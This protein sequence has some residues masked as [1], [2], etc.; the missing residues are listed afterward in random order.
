MKKALLIAAVF[1]LAV[2]LSACGEKAAETLIE[3]STNESA[4]VDIDDDSLSINTNGSSMQFGDAASVPDNF[5]SD[6]YVISG[7]VL[8]SL[9]IDET[10]GFQV[11]IETDDSVADV[12][13]EYQSQLTDD[14][15][16]IT[17]TLDVGDGMTMTGEK[18]NRYVT[19]SANV[20]DDKTNVTIITGSNE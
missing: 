4:D 1:V 3:S 8:S 2:T 9:T 6:V 7:T 16:E 19:V 5:P 13:A 17:A 10:D 20:V 12:K 11:G 18:E 14:G 15:W